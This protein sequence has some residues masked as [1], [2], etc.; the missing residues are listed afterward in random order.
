MFIYLFT[1]FS[2]KV[3]DRFRVLENENPHQVPGFYERNPKL[4]P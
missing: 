3:E 2:Q 1:V 4:T